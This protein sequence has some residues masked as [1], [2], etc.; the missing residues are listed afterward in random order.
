MQG[1]GEFF[2][3]L[4]SFEWDGDFTRY[5]FQMGGYDPGMNGWGGENLELSFR[6]WMCGGRLVVVP[7]SQASSAAVGHVFR[8]LRPYT[9][10]N[11]KDSHARNTKRAAEVWMDDYR[12]IF[13]ERK[14]VF[15]ELDAGDLTERKKLREDLNCHNFRWYLEHI[16]PGEVPPVPEIPPEPYDGGEETVEHQV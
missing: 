13:Y 9:I 11:E 16:F 10:P 4:G 5:F 3:Q 1:G 14:P 2:L 15:N 7:C 8:S 6:I 12:Y